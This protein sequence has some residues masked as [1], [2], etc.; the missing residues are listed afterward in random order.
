[1]KIARKFRLTS[2][3]VF[4]LPQ[5]STLI[6]LPPSRCTMPRNRST[7]L[8]TRSSA[9]SG[10]KRKIVSYSRS[11]VPG[12]CCAGPPLVCVSACC[13]SSPLG[14]AGG[15]TPGEVHFLLRFALLPGAFSG[16]P[17]EPVHRCRRPFEERRQGRFRGDRHPLLHHSFLLGGEPRQHEVR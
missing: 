9:R 5:F 4:F 10:R 1:M 16:P 11:R 17:V 7:I 14:F 8:S 2:Y 6:T 12:A 3:A 15:L 13:M